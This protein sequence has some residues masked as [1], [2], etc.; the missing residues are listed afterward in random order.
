MHAEPAQPAPRTRLATLLVQ[1]GAAREALA[2]L[3]PVVGASS[4]TGGNAGAGMSAGTN[5]G[6]EPEAALRLHAVAQAVVQEEPEAGAGLK[7][8]QRAVMLRRGALQPESGAES[9]SG[10]S[11]S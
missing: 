10:G 4:G 11:G 1:A 9:A 2:V 8:A 3:E 6:D 5:L 7:A